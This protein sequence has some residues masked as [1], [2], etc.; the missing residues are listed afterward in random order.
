MDPGKNTLAYHLEHPHVSVD[1]HFRQ[2]VLALGNRATAQKSFYLD[3]RYWIFLRDAHLGRAKSPLHQR[4]LAGLRTAVGTRK[5]VCPFAADIFAELLKQSDLNTRGATAEIIDQLSDGLTLQPERERIATEVLHCVQ[6]LRSRSPE[7]EP[8]RKLVWTAPAFV[9]GYTFPTWEDVPAAQAL[10]VQKAFTDHA[11]RATLAEIVAQFGDIPSELNT[12]WGDLAERLNRLNAA[13]RDNIRSFKAAV[14]EEFTGI[15]Q[16]Y[17]PEISQVV[18]YLFE[19][20][21]DGKLTSADVQHTQEAGRRIAALLLEAFRRN[22]FRTELP[23]MV[24]R[25]GLSA[26]V[27]WDTT[28]R[29]T[30]NDFHDF[31]HAAAALPYFDYFA[32]EKSLHHLI[33][34]RLKY[35]QLYD[36]RVFH[37][38]KEFIE[39]VEAL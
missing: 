13:H 1:Q 16:H 23:T 20:E 32:T 19:T 18:P 21:T 30:A 3:T 36:T 26:S 6:S 17:L 14:L 29:Y 12:G 27:R 35:D 5:A 4:L 15:L 28:R 38:P 8:L 10:A 7:L 37:D 34:R 39:A 25:A 11:W 33:T 9:L 2:K 31:G 24:I 22:R